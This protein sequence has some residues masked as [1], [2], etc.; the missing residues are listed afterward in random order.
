VLDRYYGVRALPVFSG[1]RG[2]HVYAFLQ[3]TVEFN[4]DQ[5]RLAKAVY[6]TLQ[7]KLLRGLRYK[8]LDH[9]VV[10][11]LKRL[12]RVPHTKH[13]ITGKICVPLTVDGGEV[14]LEGFSFEGYRRGGISPDV[15]QTV[16]REVLDVERMK[17]KVQAFRKKAGRRRFTTG[18]VRPCVEAALKNPN[19]NHKMRVAA[20]AEY[21]AAGYG[22]NE[23]RDLFRTQTDYEAAKTEY[24]INQIVSG[25]Y[26][27]FR[28]STIQVLG[29]C[30]PSCPIISKRI[31]E[32]HQSSQ[33]RVELLRTPRNLQSAS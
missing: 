18:R 11:D 13:E 8:T 17:A 9:E 16:V 2:Y 20:V 15:F 1:R 22:R 6:K 29:F 5:E 14:S 7:S 30:L 31:G 33:K 28:C 25:G 12:A 27:P 4:P 21:H 10:G 23:I 24:Q 26:R 19:L 32:T 3:Q